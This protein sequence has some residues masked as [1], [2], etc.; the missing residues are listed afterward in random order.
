MKTLLALLICMLSSPLCSRAGAI[1]PIDL[2]AFDA[3]MK[4]ARLPN[5]VTLAYTERGPHDGIPVVLIH[6]FTNNARNWTPLL[7]Y[8]DPRFRLIIV[9]ARGHG[10]SSRP[11]CC[12]TRLDMAYDV[13]L[14]LDQLHVSSAH[15]V[16][17]SMGSIITQM[18]AETWPERTRRVVLIGSSGGTRPGC[19]VPG[20][21]L[22]GMRETLLHMK[23]PIDPNSPFMNAWYGNA[24]APEPEV[25]RR[26][27]RDAAAIP[28]RVWLAVI[29]QGFTG[30][31]LQS[32]LQRLTAPA[33]LMWGDKDTLITEPARC[34]LREA[35]PAA[36]VHVFPD[37]GHNPYWDDPAAVAA[38][39]NPFLLQP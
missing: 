23:D 2:D 25:T 31:D 15:I 19:G 13:K 37:Y 12:Y 9:D 11:E 21:P 6:G 3:G 24:A 14:L 16:G 26:Q 1:A 32:G 27:R 38:I 18:F 34:A 4:T 7:P 10:R 28:V 22:S 39:V 30:M 35:L 33:L 36:K 29:D 5:G 20:S 8:L 17:H